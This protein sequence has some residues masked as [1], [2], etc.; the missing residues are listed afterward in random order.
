MKKRI[1]LGLIALLTGLLSSLAWASS[2]TLTLD[3]ID[4]VPE[5]ERAQFD[6]RGMPEIS[7]DSENP[8]SLV[9]SVRPEL[10]NSQVKIPGFVIPLEGDDKVVTEFLL[11]P[12]LGACIHVPPPPPNQIIYVKFADGAPIQALWDVVYVEGTLKT[13]HI[14]H[15]LAE[16]GYVLQGTTL[17][18]Y[19]DG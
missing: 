8:Q 13:E 14:S 1:T 4:L 5:H 12:F 7:H 16:V 11:V 19:D 15:D 18:A 3:W 10:N 9:G 6:S 2:E 17:S